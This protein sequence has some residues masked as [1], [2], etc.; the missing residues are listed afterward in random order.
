MV[1]EDA[2]RRKVSLAMG[3]IDYKKAF[4]SVPHSWIIA[5]L[6]IYKVNP[7]IVKFIETAMIGW[8]TEMKLYHANGCFSTGQI[9]IKRGIFQADGQTINHLLYMDDLKLYARDKKQLDQEIGIVKNFSDDISMEFGL[10]KCSRVLIKKALGTLKIGFE[11]YLEE[12]PSRVNAEQVQKIALLGTA[13]I[14]RKVL[15]IGQ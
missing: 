4:D 9:S 8:K 10:D 2:R 14:L 6:K 7:T 1:T 3:W 11:K 12:L 15:S 13:H 5:V